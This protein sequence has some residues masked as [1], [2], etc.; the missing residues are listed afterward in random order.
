MLDPEF[1]NIEHKSDELKTS[2][3]SDEIH[4]RWESVFRTDENEK[5]T[6]LLFNKVV[7]L[8]KFPE[9]RTLLDAG[10]G[11]GY[12]SIRLTRRGFKVTGIDFSSA[13][14]ENARE[15]IRKAGMEDGVTILSGNILNLPFKDS[16]YDCILCSGVLMHV[17]DI[18]KAISE[19]IRVV[20][21]GGYIFI[22]EINMNSIEAST[23]R[24][25]RKILKSN[26]KHEHMPSGI[27]YWYLV[28]GK[29]LLVR[30]T[31]SKWLIHSFSKSGFRLHSHFAGQFS[32]A[33]SWL[34]GIIFK[35]AVHG[36][37]RLYF[38]YLKMPQ[39]AF[40]NIFVFEKL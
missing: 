30:W 8:I 29:Q 11:P 19:L 15:N 21:I 7:S 33:Y 24:F 10:C 25:V 1:D 20:R 16:S 39:F 22:S 38:K 2:L 37:N 26:T 13:V 32:E 18:K 36:V 17:P 35:K 28:E 34:P 4:S 14:L 27:E 31:N 6:E 12:H 5:F 3:E 40:G 9:G 23:L